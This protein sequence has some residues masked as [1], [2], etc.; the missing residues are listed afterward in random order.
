VFTYCIRKVIEEERV[1]IEDG[2]VIKNVTVQKFQKYVSLKVNE[3]SD[4][5]ERPVSQRD[6]IEFNWAVW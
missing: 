3:L 5:K 6:N 1:D 2:N 4:G